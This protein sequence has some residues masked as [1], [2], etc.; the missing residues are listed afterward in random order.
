MIIVIIWLNT[1]YVYH[2]T[3]EADADASEKKPAIKNKAERKTKA[4][5]R[6]KKKTE[7]QDPDS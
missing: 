7:T 5:T 1:H 6:A 4:V 3:T 2:L